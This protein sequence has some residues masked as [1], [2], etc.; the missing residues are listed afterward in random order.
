MTVIQPNT[1]ELEPHPDVALVAKAL[2]GDVVAFDTLVRKY[3][4]QIFRIAQH[5]PES[6]GRRG[7]DAG[8]LFKG[9]REA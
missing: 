3:E 5:Y 4:R 6:G 9:I 1:D 2:T 7:C 8:C